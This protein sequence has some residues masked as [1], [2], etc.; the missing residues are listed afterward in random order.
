MEVCWIIGAHRRSMIDFRTAKIPVRALVS[1][2]GYY[3]VQI[4]VFVLKIGTNFSMDK[5]GSFE[6]CFKVDTF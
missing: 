2:N 5:L 3:E 6:K 4:C 1:E